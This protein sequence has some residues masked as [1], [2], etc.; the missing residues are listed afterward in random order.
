MEVK[1]RHHSQKRVFREPFGAVVCGQNVV[2]R[3]QISGEMTI[4]QCYLRLWETGLEQE[5]LVAMEPL[6]NSEVE[7]SSVWFEVKFNTPTSPG[8]VWYFF[9]LKLGEQQ[10]YYG[11]NE[12]RLGGLGQLT[13]EQPP[14]WQIT[15][16]N[17]MLIPDWYQ[18][19]IIYQIFV[20]RFSKGKTAYPEAY[21]K[22]NALVHLDWED[23]PFY[24]KDEQGRVTHWDF[25]G[26]NLDGIIEK[27]PY[28]QELG[29]S[30]LYLNPIFEAASNHKYD[31]GDYLKIDPMYGNDEIF[32]RLVKRA[33]QYGIT[34]LLDGVFSHTGSDSLYFNKKGHYPGVGAYQSPD[35]PYY[36]WY[37]FQPGSSEYKCWWN[38]EDLP[39]VDEMNFSYRQFLFG[40]EDSVI[41][42]WMKKGVA[43][44]R[45]DVADELPDAFIQELRQ[46]VKRVNPDAVLIGEVWENASNKISYGVLRQYFWGQELDGTMNYPIRKSFLHFF[47]GEWEAS[48]VHRQIMSLYETYPR[49]NFYALMNLL[50]SHDRAR[51]LTLLG[52]APPEAE[53]T[54]SE[55]RT[56]RLSAEARQ[57]AMRRLKLFCLLQMTFPGI[58]SVYYGDEAGMEG[59]AD[60]YNRG[61][62]PWGKEDQELENWFKRMIRWRKEYEVLQTGDF[63]SFYYGDDVYGFQR[64]SGEES[65]WVLVNRNPT[66]MQEVELDL[67]LGFE[68]PSVPLVIDLMSSAV[69]ALEAPEKL[70]VPINPLSARVL[71]AKKGLQNQITPQLSRACGVLLHISSL[72]STWGR[73]DLGQS[74]FCF[75][76][77]LSSAH[78]SL[79][80]I[81]PL[82]PVGPGNSPYQSDSVFA[83][84]P[85][86]ISFDSLIREGLLHA[87]TVQEAITSDF[88]RDKEN[89]LRHAFET[90]RALLKKHSERSPYLT[91]ENYEMFLDENSDWIGDYGLFCALKKHFQGAPWFDWEIGISMRTPEKL[92]EYAQ[93]LAEEI[94]FNRF[95]QYTFY[96]QWQELKEYATAKKVKIIGDMPLYVAADSCEVWVNRELFK[97]D[98]QGKPSWVAGVPPDYFSTTGQRWANPLYDWE[99]HATT[100]YNWWKKR[101][102][103]TQRLFDFT[104][105]DHFRG[106]EAYWEI[107]AREETAIKGHWLKGPG[108]HFFENLI[109]EFG[110]LP[111]LA[112]NLGLI[113]PEVET[114]RQIFGFPG[115]NV[116]QFTP[117]AEVR[118]RVDNQFIYYSGTHDN[119][120]LLGWYKSTLAM[121]SRTEEE[122]RLACQKLI[123]D[124]YMSPAAWVILPLQ[125]ILGLDSE[126]RM[127]VPGTVGTNWLWQVPQ[128]RLTDEVREYLQ[129]LTDRAQRSNIT[130]LGNFTIN[131][132]SKKSRE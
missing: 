85:L 51:V 27:L 96:T 30:I 109:A 4:D 112:E 52:D 47:R 20:D 129:N 97:L 25:F 78:Q 105:I 59:F 103:Q 15:V 70:T 100:Q 127:N 91:L 114:L 87:E 55:R 23:T 32:D 11:N 33:K 76:D 37:Q 8:L 94:E 12:E 104:R 16:Y 93:K 79:W 115:M 122:C 81:L 24:I 28:L 86:L 118:D 110:K 128:E 108:K 92:E 113:T 40:T 50:G 58:P 123:E 17:P 31:T 60:P 46:A 29:I 41:Q 117:L 120:T 111:L 7:Q 38:T 71:F 3:L 95:V 6:G 107:D 77:Y 125:D 65:I 73:G 124:L 130:E 131:I 39:E 116:L 106:L 64:A 34:L 74:A 45:L 48:E 80:Q 43:G 132:S 54:D 102:K 62:F 126:A 89:L 35:S 26:G 61:T 99:V 119:D 1:I 53:L 88:S 83:G 57:L 13:E 121:D 75:I 82:N 42:K 69:L 98:E 5:K 67:K 18:R 19:G 72:P 2:I 84:N 49:E 90:F 63:R 56:F 68:L 44:W 10:F 9:I 21:I 101:I 36:S 14:A 22:K 66:A